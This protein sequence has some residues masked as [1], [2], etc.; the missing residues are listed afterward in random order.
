M[1][2][3]VKEI[4]IETGW[5]VSTDT[6]S[7][8]TQFEFSKFTPAGQDFNFTVEVKDN[9]ISQLT[10]NIL[11]YYESFDPDYEASLW[12]GEDGH[13]KNGAPYSIKDIVDDMESA[14]EMVYELYEKLLTLTDEDYE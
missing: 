6:D 11:E 4:A 10:N 9:N 2:E 13:G 7:G 8:C 1:I 12:I 5:S 14:E 3:R